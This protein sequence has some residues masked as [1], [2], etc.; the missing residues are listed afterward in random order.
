MH[1][2]TQHS[3]PA[4]TP[5]IGEKYQHWKGDTYTV[6][7]IS[8][9]ENDCHTIMVSYQSDYGREQG[10]IPWSRPMYDAPNAFF[11]LVPHEDLKD[12]GLPINDIK[13]FILIRN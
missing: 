11:G 3:L 8:I 4:E 6:T 5:K 9:L 12:F 7:G 13:R 1:H 10:L 2:K